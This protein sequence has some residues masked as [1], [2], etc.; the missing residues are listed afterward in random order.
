MFVLIF[1]ILLFI[2]L[3]TAIYALL[4]YTQRKSAEAR[5]QDE[6]PEQRAR[7]LAAFERR[8]K[9]KRVFYVFVLPLVLGGLLLFVAMR[10]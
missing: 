6:E 1:R 9:P 8:A 10:N 3:L 4:S 2:L 5:F 7:D